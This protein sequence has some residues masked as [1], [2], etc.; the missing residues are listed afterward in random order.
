MYFVDLEKAFD[1]VR[2][3]VAERALRKKRL[4][5]VL[6]QAVMSFY[7]GLK[8]K[9]RGESGLLKKFGLGVGVHQGSLL[10]PL[11]LATVADVVTKDTRKRS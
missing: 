2:R 9:I 3:K 7:K 10:S 11:I 1:R 5:K 4:P 8:M 6:V